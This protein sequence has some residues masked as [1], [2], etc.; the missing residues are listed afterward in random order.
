MI[1]PVGIVLVIGLLTEIV[2][3][4]PTVVTPVIF[5]F[6]WIPV[7][8]FLTSCPTNTSEFVVNTNWEEPAV[9]EL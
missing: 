1:V 5:V 8:V 9:A 6:A 3:R 4:P 2:V 7:T